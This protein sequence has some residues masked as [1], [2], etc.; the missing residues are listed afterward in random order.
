MREQEAQHDAEQRLNGLL[1]TI[2]ESAVELVGF[3]AATVTARHGRD[4]A[5]VQATDQRLVA[6]DDAQYESGEG[7]CLQVLDPHDPIYLED[8]GDPDERWMHYAQ[9]AEHL[10]VESSLSIHLPID[11][12]TVAGSLNLYARRRVEMSDEDIQRALRF[13]S[14]ISAAMESIDAHRATAEEYRSTAKLAQD[15]AEAMRSRAVIEQAK[16]MLMADHHISDEE[17]FTM[18]VRL[19]QRSNVKVRDV[20]R[21]LVHTR[22]GSEPR[23]QEPAFDHVDGDHDLQT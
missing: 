8:A 15:M 4:V 3:D 2:L 13:A 14:Q 5:T 10:G 22:S 7:P 17:A 12:E 23:D 19:S 18:L 16:G 6:L 9:T 11:N 20:A 1:S 21:R